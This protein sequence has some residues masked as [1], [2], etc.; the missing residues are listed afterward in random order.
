MDDS[1]EV[2]A[3]VN[4][5]RDDTALHTPILDYGQDLYGRSRVRKVSAQRL[6][7]LLNVTEETARKLV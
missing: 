1:D 6:A 7:K 2:Y 4:D 3:R 5:R